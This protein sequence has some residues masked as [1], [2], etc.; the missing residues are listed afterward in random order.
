MRNE[1]VG[2]DCRISLQAKNVKTGKILYSGQ[3]CEEDAITNSGR[4]QILGLLGNIGS[5]NVISHM[6]IGT[7]TT[8]ETATDTMLENENCT[9]AAVTCTFSGNSMNI[10]A[11]FGAGNGTGDVTELGCFDTST[12][13]TGDMTNRKTFSAKAKG[14]DDSFTFTLTFTIS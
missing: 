2:L 9:R 4:Q 3:L 12:A 6:A 7:G 13:D 8:S 10:E 1:K 14:A 5:K 11:T